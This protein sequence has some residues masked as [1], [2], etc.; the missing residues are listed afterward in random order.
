[1]VGQRL[2][3]EV[4]GP[5]GVQDDGTRLGDAVEQLALGDAGDE[6]L[7]ERVAV[8]AVEGVAQGVD[9]HG[10]VHPL[11]EDPVQDVPAAVGL[12]EG[13]SEQVGEQV[14][15]DALVAQ[16][17]GEAVVLLLGAVHPQHVVEEQPVLVAG[18]QAEQLR[19]GAVQDHLAQASDLG[20]DPEWSGTGESGTER[21]TVIAPFH[22]L[23]APMVK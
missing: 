5:E 15:G 3:H 8:E 18:G 20:V 23:T 6:V 14:H 13:A 21:G 4:V 1:M 2:Q 7:G 11:V 10:A 12:L 9:G 22:H 16:H 17:L 19:A